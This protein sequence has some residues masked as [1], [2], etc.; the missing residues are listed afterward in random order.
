MILPLLLAGSALGVPIE[1]LFHADLEGELASP[2]CESGRPEGPGLASLVTALG[3][4][5]EAA[6]ARGEPPPVTILGGDTLSPDPFAEALFQADD[7]GIDTAVQA[8][9][10]AGYDAIGF[11]EHELDLR[12]ERL[13]RLAR[14]L[15]DAGMPLLLSNIER[16]D[17]KRHPFC[18]VVRRE[19][20]VQR[21]QVRV[22]I[23]SVLWPQALRGLR[24]DARDGLSLSDPGAT[25]P[26]LV[27]SLRERADVVLVVTQ[28]RSEDA[29]EEARLL[30]GLLRGRAAPDAILSGGLYGSVDRPTL[31]SLRADDGTPVVGSAAGPGS[32]SRLR[33]SAEGALAAVEVVTTGDAP[34]D[35]ATAALL[36]RYVK[37]YCEHLGARVA[38]LGAPLDREAFLRYLL[39]AMQR[40]T[41]A[42]LALVRRAEVRRR[43]FPM[44][45]QVVAADLYRAVP[46]E[47]RLAVVRVPGSVLGAFLHTLAT[48]PELAVA[49]LE[50][51]LPGTRSPRINGRPFD[52]TRAYRIATSTLVASGADRL[53]PPGEPWMADEPHPSLAEVTVDA[54]RSARAS[55]D[56]AIDFGAPLRD[57]GLLVVSGDLGADFMDVSLSDTAKYG[58]KI[59]IAGA[60]LR[61]IRLSFDGR[62]DLDDPIHRLA[63]RL[64]INYSYLRLHMQ[65][66]PAEEGKGEDGITFTAQYSYRGWIPR[67]VPSSIIPAP[68]TRLLVE[69]EFEKPDAT[70]MITR[71]YHHLV[72]RH[73][74]GLSWMLLPSLHARAGA[75]YAKELTASEQSTDPYEAA[76]SRLRF[77]TEVGVALAPVQLARSFPLRVEAEAG[78]VLLDPA[79]K[80]QHTIDGRASLV[81]PLLP[82]LQFLVGNELFAI[83]LAG[84]GWSSTVMTMVGLR[85]HL[86]AAHQWHE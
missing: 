16:C 49:G 41:G 84:L 29:L 40:R 63:N 45:G 51:P 72:V 81:L 11:G 8:F 76:V 15:A 2:A 53:L 50:P 54:L 5:R 64:R 20:I 69:T 32:L 52:P 9:S 61:Q 46:T 14:R 85:V 7:Q 26:G 75:G 1:V 22:G 35:P 83:H 56:P 38:S 74:G 34:A 59:G 21:G 33:F 31:R 73:T 47:A 43:G 12:P 80:V 42:E 65:G 19:A 36:S 10:R 25:L 86:D 79:G 82:A 66:R 58:G 48:T 13:G 23:L 17:E 70:Q 71:T 4:A 67:D 30:M 6:A 28:G 39:A 60:D 44:S 55:L 37:Y 3:K 57:R 18:G 68:Y 24:P 77:A 62:V 78:Y 27:Q